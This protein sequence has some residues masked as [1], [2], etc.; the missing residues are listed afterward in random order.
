MRDVECIANASQAPPVASPAPRPSSARVDGSSSFASF[1][2]MLRR[3]S[4]SVAS[5]SSV[6]SMDNQ[7]L[8]SSQ[9][10]KQ[11]S[12]LVAGQVPYFQDRRSVSHSLSHAAGMQAS[13]PTRPRLSDLDRSFG[14][15]RVLRTDADEI[16]EQ[17][18]LQG[19]EP[20]SFN[21]NPVM[22]R[23]HSLPRFTP[24]PQTRYHQPDTAP[25]S[26]STGNFNWRSQGYRQSASQLPNQR[27]MSQ[28]PQGAFHGR[29]AHHSN[30][31]NSAFVQQPIQKSEE[32]V[33]DEH[34]HREI[35]ETNLPPGIVL[36]GSLKNIEE[37]PQS[38]G[39]PHV[40]ERPSLNV[41]PHWKRN[42]SNADAN[43]AHQ[44]F[45]TNQRY[46]DQNANV[47]RRQTASI[48]CW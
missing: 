15:M 38:A 40:S 9:V 35:L 39:T 26:Q 13:V 36:S 37:R 46:S 6:G 23:V 14:K 33:W 48:S 29:E 43:P 8:Y 32:T 1:G 7:S 10:D 5:K 27:P 2:N 21:Q 44:Q 31:Q 11:G 42:Q 30:P 12:P 28:S 24:N 18:S 17:N 25:Q 3:K 16:A 22:E 4:H 45:T 19:E 20:Q 34:L 41:E 47:F